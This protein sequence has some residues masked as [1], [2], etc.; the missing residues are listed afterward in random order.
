MNRKDAGREGEHHMKILIAGASGVV[1]KRLIPLLV[2][3]HQVFGTTRTAGKAAELHAAGVEPVI[4]DALDRDA[5]RRAVGS[6]R[7]EVI[8]HQ[9]TALAKMQSPKHF[10]R[11]LAITNRLR[12]EGTDNLLAAAR[13]T[14]VHRFVAQSF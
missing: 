11:E 9:M 5:V 12:T 6:V 7:P 13:E 8:V 10:D 4:L 2:G 14:G 3:R 1:G